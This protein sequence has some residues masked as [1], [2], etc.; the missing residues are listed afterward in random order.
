MMKYIAIQ[1]DVQEKKYIE[2][3]PPS[4]VIIIL[5]ARSMNEHTQHRT[6]F[7]LLFFG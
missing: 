1:K 7:F 3:T 2:V 5:H 4:Q 6:Y